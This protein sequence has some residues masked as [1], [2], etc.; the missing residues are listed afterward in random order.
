[1]R[2]KDELFQTATL[3]RNRSVVKHIKEVLTRRISSCMRCFFVSR[4]EPSGFSFR[5][6]RSLYNVSKFGLRCNVTGSTGGSMFACVGLWMCNGWQGGRASA[7]F[8]VYGEAEGA[9]RPR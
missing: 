8:G 2:K 9:A 7:L 3:E 1:M 5:V 4:V 6:Q